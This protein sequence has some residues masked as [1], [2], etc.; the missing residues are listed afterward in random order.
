LGQIRRTGNSHRAATA[1]DTTAL[2]IM[3]GFADYVNQGDEP[4][5]SGVIRIID[6]RLFL[7]SSGIIG[8]NRS[9]RPIP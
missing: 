1:F 4:A 6:K 2:S 8:L 7:E 9:I 3:T 5:K